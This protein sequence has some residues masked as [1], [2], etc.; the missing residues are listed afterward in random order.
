MVLLDGPNRRD[1]VPYVLKNENLSWIDS[2]LLVHQ[3]SL[4][5]DA[6]N[7]KAEVI[8]LSKVANTSTAICCKNSYVLDN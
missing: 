7:Q 2:F 4:L 6:R 8:K 5:D 1:A 3:I